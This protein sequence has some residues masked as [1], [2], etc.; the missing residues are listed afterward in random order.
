MLHHL[1]SKAGIEVKQ[2]LEELLQ[3]KVIE[4]SL[5]ENLVLTDIGT[6]E[7]ALWSL[8]LYAGYLNVVST[9]LM[10][11]RLVTKISIPNKE[12]GFVYDN[13]VK[14]WFSTAISLS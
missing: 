9:E 8:L 11:G 10:G 13:I 1:L 14:Q 6:K 5:S 12:V 4:R 3:G 7:E 2:Q